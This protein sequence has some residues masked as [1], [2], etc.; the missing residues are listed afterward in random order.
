MRVL[1]TG[2]TGFIGSHVVAA[3]L[4]RL[5]EAAIRVLSRRVQTAHRWGRRVQVVQGNVTQPASLAAA[6]T[7]VDAVIHCVQFPGNPVEDPAR[8]WTWWN[9]DARGTENLAAAA[10]AWGC[11]RFVYLSAAGA[12]PGRTEPWL[13]AKAAAEQAIAAS[14]LAAVVLRPT[15]VY[16]PGDRRVSRMARAIRRLPV[17]PILGRGDR[18][19]QPVLAFDVAAA[20]VAALT[21]DDLTGRTLELGGPDILPIDGVAR[22]V[23]QV[24]GIRRPLVHVPSSLARAASGLISALP[25]PP[26]SPGAV[27]YLIAESQAD[28]REAEQL[29]KIRFE[30]LE[31]GLARWLGPQAE[32]SGS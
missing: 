10:R 14:G 23:Q 2:G 21:M 6:L 27:D 26:L 13:R 9:V 19:V 17:L 12:A 11:R 30:R 8:G 25:A 4:A 31:P 3:L 28:P 1:V 29:L 16:G 22:S 32:E 5:P 15:W 7:G 20:A 24:L 18:R